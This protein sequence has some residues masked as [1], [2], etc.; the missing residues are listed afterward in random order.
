M[1]DRKE[2]Q[3]FIIVGDSGSGKTTIAKMFSDKLKCEC[4]GFSYAGRELSKYEPN[5]L[6]FTAI[7]DYIYKCIENAV[8]RGTPVVVEGLSAIS[9]FDRLEYAGYK[10]LVI[11]IDVPLEIRIRRIAKRQ[12]CS[13]EIAKSIEKSKAEGKGKAGIDEVIKKADIAI[14]GTEEMSFVLKNVIE[15]VRIHSSN[16]DNGIKME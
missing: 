10:M 5:S 3:I 15:T 2:V 8:N 11:Y 7:N 4:L 14:D 9:V 6:P 13:L 1:Y 12:N 16:N